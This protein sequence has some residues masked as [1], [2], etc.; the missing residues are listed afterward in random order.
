M[1]DINLNPQQE[2]IQKRKTIKIIIIC[3]IVAL[4]TLAGIYIITG[5]NYNGENNSGEHLNNVD[6]RE[7]RYEIAVPVARTSIDEKT[8]IT[9]SVVQFVRKELT[10]EEYDRLLE[11]NYMNSIEIIGRWLNVGICMSEGDTFRRGGLISVEDLPGSWLTLLN[12]E[13]I[14][15]FL[16][17]DRQSTFNNSIR[18]FDYINVYVTAIISGERVHGRLAEDIQ[19]LAV[20]DRLGR[21]VFICNEA[22]TD[23]G[24]IYFGLSEEKQLLFRKAAT[25]QGVNIYVI[26]LNRD[27]MS[28]TYRKKIATDELINFIESSVP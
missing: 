20:K 2:V 5:D 10:R 22:R 18:P 28:T 7:Q 17:V 12:S 25:I 23:S 16:T 1:N 3:M 27:F 4:A 6:E 24:F 14:P 19:I 26:P 8:Q 15:Y 11:E 13:Q 21:N 9:N